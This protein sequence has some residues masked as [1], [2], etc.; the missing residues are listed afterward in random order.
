MNKGLA[1]GGRGLG[2]PIEAGKEHLPEIA[3]KKAKQSGE[4]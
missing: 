3:S 4:T 2:K 1:K